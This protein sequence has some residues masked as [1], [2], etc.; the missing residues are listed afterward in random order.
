[1]LQVR[2]SAEELGENKSVHEIHPPSRPYGRLHHGPRV[3]EKDGGYISD[4]VHLRDKVEMV[5][6]SSDMEKLMMKVEEMVIIGLTGKEE[7][8]SRSGTREQRSNTEMMGNRTVNVDQY[9]MTMVKLTDRNKKAL[10]RYGYL[11]YLTLP[12]A[13][14]EASMDARVTDRTFSVNLLQRSAVHL[15]PVANYE[16]GIC[17]KQGS[18]EVEKKISSWHCV[19]LESQVRVGILA[20]WRN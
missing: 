1:M 14:F 6:S 8:G 15:H 17:Y 12:D 4:L 20:L 3:V 13:V 5:A 9:L 10:S 16:L 2:Y 11:D 19:T 18:Y 7:S